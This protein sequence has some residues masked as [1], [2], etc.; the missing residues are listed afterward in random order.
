M[1]RQQAESFPFPLQS[2]DFCIAVAHVTSLG[3]GVAFRY[4]PR[5]LEPRVVHLRVLS[6]TGALG[7]ASRS[8]LAAAPTGD[9]FDVCRLVLLSAVF[10]A[11]SVIVRPDRVFP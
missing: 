11:A 9:V 10:G 3:I 7:V 2:F 6:G 8:P 1:L 4:C 5:S